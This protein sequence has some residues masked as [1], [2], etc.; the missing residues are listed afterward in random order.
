M[1]KRTRWKRIYLPTIGQRYFH[2]DFGFYRIKKVWQCE[3]YEAHCETPGGSHWFVNQKA[4][5]ITEDGLK[6]TVPYFQLVFHSVDET[7]QF[8]LSR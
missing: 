6:Y 1:R 8:V 2:E 3:V 5:I 4:A 7:G